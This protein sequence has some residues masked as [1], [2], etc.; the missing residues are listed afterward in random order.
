ME[1]K[2]EWDFWGKVVM[3]T[4]ATSG[5]GK[6]A[7]LELAKKGASLVLPCRS[8]EKGIETKKW[9]E[10]KTGSENVEILPMDLAS[11]D[12]IRKGAKLFK[13]RFK[14]LH[15]LINNA[16]IMP[17]SKEMKR[18]QDGYELIFGVNV[19]APFLLTHLLSEHLV[20]GSGRVVNISSA[21]HIPG[22]KFGPEVNF[23]FGNLQGEKHYDPTLFYKNSKLALMWFTYEL[24]RRLGWAGVTVNAMCP[25]FVPESISEHQK[26]FQKWMFRHILSRLPQATSLKKAGQM[27]AWMASAP[28]LEE[29]S[30]GFFVDFQVA[31]SSEESYDKEKAAKCWDLLS[32]MSG[33]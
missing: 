2:N 27:E 14:Q 17:A 16:G 20:N 28:E 32:R 9:I 5:I 7:A 15:I 19:L 31:K 30:G 8:K 25:G 18:T 26:G 33:L 24:D 21:L 11:L 1:K 29:E 12:S 22:Q 6:T 23:D 13:E 3:I 4:G 10:E